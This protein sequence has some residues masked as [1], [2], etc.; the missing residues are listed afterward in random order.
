MRNIKIFRYKKFAK[1]F[2]KEVGGID[3]EVKLANFLKETPDAGVVI[4]GS[5][6]VRKLRW[7]KPSKGKS[8][9]VRIIYYFY[10]EKGEVYLVTLFAKKDKENLSDKEVNEMAK[11][12]KQIKEN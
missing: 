4:K 1:L 11:L 2:K 9:G 7:A 3:E 10:N 12:I 6:G 5:G 8:G